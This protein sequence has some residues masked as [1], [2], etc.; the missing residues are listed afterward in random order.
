MNKIKFIKKNSVSN[1][2]L[3]TKPYET[4]FTK[5]NHKSKGI[6]KVQKVHSK[7]VFQRSPNSP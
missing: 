6:P 3:E 5:M 4:T 7:K 2:F 1:E